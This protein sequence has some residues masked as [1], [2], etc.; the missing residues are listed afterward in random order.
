MNKMHAPLISPLWLE[1]CM[2]TEERLDEIA[3]ILAQ[4]VLR[5][6]EYPLTD[7]LKSSN[8]VPRIEERRT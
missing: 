5:S 1:E 2:S 4:G 7:S 3:A 8:K 6:L